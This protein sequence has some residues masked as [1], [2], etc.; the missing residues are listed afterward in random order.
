MIE[1]I[2]IAS[3]LVS[4]QYTVNQLM[5]EVANYSQHQ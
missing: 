5:L 3:E 4:H 2:A 1:M